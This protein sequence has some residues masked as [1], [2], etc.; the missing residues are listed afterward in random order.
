[1]SI[2]DSFSAED[3]SPEQVEQLL[4]KTPDEL[5]S[6]ARSLASIAQNAA[7]TAYRGLDE[8]MFAVAQGIYSAAARAE[9]AGAEFVTSNAVAKE[10]RE[11]YSHLPGAENW[12]NPS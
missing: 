7:G 9:E 12:A 1:M 6:V 5:R 10:F 2:F 4:Q 11:Q 3:A 8:G